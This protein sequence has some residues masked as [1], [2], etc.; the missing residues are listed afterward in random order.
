MA[1]NKLKFLF[2]QILKFLIILPTI[3]NSIDFLN[4]NEHEKKDHP[5]SQP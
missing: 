4:E 1:R 5:I 3:I 2:K